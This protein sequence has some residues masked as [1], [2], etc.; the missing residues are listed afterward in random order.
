[1]M[2]IVLM[3]FGSGLPL[4]LVLG[5]LQAWLTTSGIDI[6]TIGVFSLVRFPYLLKFVWSP[7]M[8]RFVPP[9][10]GRRR[11]WILPVQFLLIIS[12]SAMALASPAKMPLA[13]AVIAIVVAFVSASQDIVV[14]AYRTDIVDDNERKPGAAVSIFGYRIA[15]LV[16]GPL[17]F[18]AAD[19]MGW[20]NTYFCMAIFMIVGISGTLLGREPDAQVSPPKTLEQAVYKPLKDFFT[21]KHALVLILFI[22][23]YKLG[24]AYATALS[25]AFLLRGLHFTL[26]E[27]GTLYKAIGIIATIVG[28]LFG[29]ALMVRLGLYRSLMFFGILQMVSNLSFMVLAWTGKNY[30]VMITAVLFENVAGGMGSAAFVAFVM[31]LCNRSYSATQY[32]LLSSFAA[33]GVFAISPSAG[34]VVQAV[35]WPIF[36]LITTLA[37]LPGLVILRLLRED[38]RA[39]R[40]V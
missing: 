13:L 30:S 28:A 1:M 25:T 29:G 3:G 36:F 8:D 11:G 20:Q 31:A 12:I 7:L 39:I 19:R 23:L 24:D 37:A 38:I 18:I 21:R 40:E 33:W 6:R 34:F 2:T 9:W 5:T 26:T 17:A 15:M 10:L 14:D 16:S 22:I 35:G 27:V 32:A 4:P